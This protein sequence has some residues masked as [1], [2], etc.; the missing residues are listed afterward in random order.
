MLTAGGSFAYLVPCRR[1]IIDGET[2]TDLYCLKDCTSPGCHAM[3]LIQIKG[4][5]H[6]P[7]TGTLIPHVFCQR[8]GKSQLMTSGE[9]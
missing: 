7:T 3:S 1:D 6:R 2:D 9:Q 8:L 4:L 5:N